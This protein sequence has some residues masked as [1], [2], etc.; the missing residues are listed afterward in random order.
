MNYEQLKN[1]LN[2]LK[3]YPS[4]SFFLDHYSREELEQVLDILAITENFS[5]IN[6]DE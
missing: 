1:A 5:L 4:I 6:L 2:F 3:E